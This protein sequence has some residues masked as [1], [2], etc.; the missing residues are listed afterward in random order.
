MTPTRVASEACEDRND[1][2]LKRHGR[3]LPMQGTEREAESEELKEKIEAQGVRGSRFRIETPDRAGLL[4]LALPLWR[5]APWVLGVMMGDAPSLQP[6]DLS[7]LGDEVR[8]GSC[9]T[10][11]R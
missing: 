10:L 7:F 11:L 1:F 4:R 3:I 6:E 9:P 8:F 2:V 5:K